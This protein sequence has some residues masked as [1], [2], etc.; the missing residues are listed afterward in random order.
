MKSV[1]FFELLLWPTTRLVEHGVAASA[2]AR[3]RFEETGHVR[4]LDPAWAPTFGWWGGVAD[5]DELAA[6]SGK[7][8]DRVRAYAKERG[9]R[10]AHKKLRRTHAELAMGLWCD[11]TSPAVE[12][13]R[14]FGVLPGERRVLC[15]AAQILVDVTPGGIRAVSAWPLCH[16]EARF[17][18]LE[19]RMQ[20]PPEVLRL[21]VR[22]PRS[23]AVPT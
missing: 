6:L 2:V 21:A 14:R 8:A 20:P 23:T 13:C 4:P 5:V 10:F 22:S 16:L 9:L 12:S 17:A 11:R 3:L 15:A 18:K 19:L 7:S 1:G